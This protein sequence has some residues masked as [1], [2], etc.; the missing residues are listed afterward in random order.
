MYGF[1]D[2]HFSSTIME[3][4]MLFE[5]VLACNPYANGCALFTEI[6][7]CPTILSSALALT[8]FALPV[9]LPHWQGI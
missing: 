3:L 4:G 7:S 9:I 8:T 1:N 5:I 6:S 2:G